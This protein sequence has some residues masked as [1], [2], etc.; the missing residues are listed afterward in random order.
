MP[1]GRAAFATGIPPVNRDQGTPVPRGF[2]LQL[3]D[4]LA[5]ADIVNRLSPASDA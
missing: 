5:P 1:T 4:E 3:A 2:V